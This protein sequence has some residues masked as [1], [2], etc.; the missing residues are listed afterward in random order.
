MQKEREEFM[1]TRK[2]RLVSTLLAVAMMFVMLPVGVFAAGNIIDNEET[3]VAAI[4]GASGNSATITVS[5]TITISKTLV[6][7]GKNI[8]LQGGGK[9]IAAEN[10]TAESDSMILLKNNASL[11]TQNIAL[12]ANKKARVL[13][14][15]GSSALIV[16]NGTL[17]THGAPPN[18]KAGMSGGGIYVNWN[19]IGSVYIRGGKITENECS[20]NK[21]AGGV[22]ITNS[23]SNYFEMTGGEVSYNIGGGVCIRQEVEH[24]IMTGG[25]VV[26]NTGYGVDVNN[27]K[28]VLGGDIEITNNKTEAG[29]ALDLNL[30][31]G[32]AATADGS[33]PYTFK[34]CSALN[35]DIGIY[36]DYNAPIDTVIAETSNGYVLSETDVEHL[37]VGGTAKNQQELKFHLFLVNNQ[38]VVKDAKTVIFNANDD[39]TTPATVTQLLPVGVE[40]ALKTNSFA[41][42]GYIFDSWNTLENGT[43]TEYSDGAKVTLSDDIT[44][45]AQWEAIPDH[46][47]TV[48][49]GTFTVK[50][51]TVETKTEGDKLIANVPE[52]AEVTVTF[53]KAAYADS[54]LVFGGW[55]ISGLDDKENYANKEEFTFTMPETGVTIEARTKTADTE[56]DSWDAA[57]VITG[58]AIGAG[59]AVLTYHI[60]TELYAEQVLGKG[61]SVPKT[62]EDVAL[63]AWELAGKPAVELNGEPLSEA[64]QAEKWATESGLMQNDAEGNFNG[65]K[66]MSK[67][68]ALRVLDKAQ[69]LA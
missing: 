40:K 32:G 50:D 44:L 63:K 12:D 30:H 26:N 17:I 42:K 46:Q 53:N 39:T 59:A 20:S 23:A 16:E 11:T 48:T 56:D 61:V 14:V 33:H 47:L 65:T 13:N 43:G 22:Y 58:V 68:K 8:T 25:K 34:I 5:G 31:S 18:G 28:L 9:I 41:R 29:S 37:K 69:K 64:A 27:S 10:F 51:E 57:T 52:G 66:K 24:A 2:M 55:E 67:L 21:T 15:S 35:G 4:N 19:D 49:G 60:G 38:V 1:R 62:R 45:Y 3:L 36:T 6:I 54:N 7:D